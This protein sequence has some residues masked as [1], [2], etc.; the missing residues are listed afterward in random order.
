M[1]NVTLASSAQSW[2]EIVNE[3]L[4]QELALNNR[5]TLTGFVPRST[6]EQRKHAK[7]LHF[8]LVDAKFNF[9]FSGEE[10]LAFPPDELNIDILVMHS[11][12]GAD[13]RQG[14]IIKDIKNCKWVL[15]VHTIREKLDRFVNK[16]A[17]SAAVKEPEHELQVNLCEKADLVVAVGPQVAEAVKAALRYCGKESDIFTLMPNIFSELLGVRHAFDLKSW[18]ANEKFRVLISGSV[19][20]F[21]VK[22]CDIAAKAITLLQDSSYHLIIVVRP[23]DDP[24]EIVS[25][26]HDS[27]ISLKQ[28]TVRTCPGTTEMWYRLLC[29]V[30]LLIQPTRAE[31]FGMSGLRAISADLPLL[32]S[33]NCG[34]GIA[35]KSL[36]SGE[37][38]VVDSDEPDIWANKLKEVRAKG[39]KTCHFQAK[40]LRIEYTARFKWKEQVNKLVDI[41]SEMSQPSHG[42]VKSQFFVNTNVVLVFKVRRLN[43]MKFPTFFFFFL[44]ISGLFLRVYYKAYVALCWPLDLG[45]KKQTRQCSSRANYHTLGRSMELKL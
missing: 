10:L 8:Q 40:Q 16:S 18:D 43:F 3:Q 25:A 7:K 2:N 17:S 38:S 33:T 20:Y 31:R 32:V 37:S 24:D 27:G 6:E 41:I 23:N 21:E 9:G 35:M 5:I 1:L 19:K 30:D 22:G 12:G 4:V 29:E 26:M 15:V 42:M 13:G 44:Y 28:L 36:P 39:P 11:Y 45:K 14:Q 34:L